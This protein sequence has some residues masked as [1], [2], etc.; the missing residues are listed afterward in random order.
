MVLPDCGCHCETAWMR[1]CMLCLICCACSI[2][3][4]SYYELEAEVQP[5]P[6]RICHA[7]CTSCII[8]P[9]CLGAGV[10]TQGR[11]TDT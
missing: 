11:D 9:C 7:A 5:M 8:T 4:T 1:K 3:A 10:Q 6:C 2:D